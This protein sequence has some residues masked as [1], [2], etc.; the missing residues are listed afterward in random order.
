MVY[1]Y[2]RTHIVYMCLYAALDAAHAAL[3][4]TTPTL[5]CIHALAHIYII[6]CLCALLNAAL[7][8]TRAHVHASARAHTATVQ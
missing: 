5:T 7:S 4:Y 3:K 6:L 2:A 1:S 8:L